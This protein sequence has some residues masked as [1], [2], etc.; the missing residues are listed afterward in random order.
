MGELWRRIVYLFNRRRLEAELEADMEFHRE[1][2]AR[3]GQNNFGNVLRISPPLNISK[4]DVDEF[5]RLLDA[6]FVKAQSALAVA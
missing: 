6:S 2:A 4:T 5:A 3:A 1:M